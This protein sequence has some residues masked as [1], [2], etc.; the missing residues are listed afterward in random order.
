MS[1][2][3]F[4]K[5]LK[6]IDAYTR[7]KKLIQSYATYYNKKRPKESS[8]KETHNPEYDILRKHHRFVQ[9]Q[10]DDKEMTWEQR[11]AQKYYEQLF[12]EY[13][14]C[15]LSYYKQGKIALRWR[16]ESEVVMG[17]GQFIC[18]ST[19]CDQTTHLTS[20]EVNFGYMEDGIKK[21]ELVKVRLCED[22]SY[23]LNYKTQKRKVKQK[24]KNKKKR[25]LDE[26]T[27]DNSDQDI[28]NHK[29]LIKRK[30]TKD[31]GSPENDD[32][33]T[34]SIWSSTVDTKDEKTKEEEFEDYFADLLQ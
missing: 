27:S 19:R 33:K 26:H 29:G 18:A 23:K 10:I 16:T 32:H 22:C 34:S 28:G 12:K 24:E 15:E 14:L 13:A 20:W 17:K 1:Q 3:V 7:H 6:G 9:P 4:R 21:N 11:L 5:E 31:D 2:F 25:K 8:N 30:K